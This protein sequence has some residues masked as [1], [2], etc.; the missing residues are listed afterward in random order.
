MNMSL[1]NL[2]NASFE[3][4][5]DISDTYTINN[6]V[7]SLRDRLRSSPQYS[8]IF[9]RLVDDINHPPCSISRDCNSVFWTQKWEPY[10]NNYEPFCTSKFQDSNINGRVCCAIYL[11]IQESYPNIYDF[12]KNSLNS[13]RD[14]TADY[15]LIMKREYYGKSLIP[16]Y[17]PVLPTIPQNYNQMYYQNTGF[18][19]QLFCTQ[20][21]KRLTSDSIFC[22]GCGN[23]IR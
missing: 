11:L 19:N 22:T 17:I 13:I 1:K 7:Y 21:G 20:C 8:I 4:T 10:A 23:K 2:I 9:Q 3:L 12:P 5:R 14:D 15:Q 6:D 18:R 16:A